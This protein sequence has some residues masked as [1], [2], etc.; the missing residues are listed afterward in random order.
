MVDAVQ[1]AVAVQKEFHAHNVELPE[2]RRMLFR[3]GVNL[4]D[5]IEE[6][7]RI[8]G[9]GV[10][11]AARIESI[12]DP[13]GICVSKTAFDHIESKLPLGY[14]FLGEQTVKNIAKPVG[15]YKVLMES[16]IT[17]KPAL[18][19]VPKSRPPKTLKIALVCLSALVV[20]VGA[21][22]VW[23][24][25]LHRAPAP[26]GKVDLRKVV[27]APAD[28]TSIEVLPFQN[29]TGDHEQEYF[30]DGMAEQLI[31]GL[32]QTPDIYVAARTSS[33]AFKGK[34]MTAQQISEQL[35]VRYLLEGSVQRDADRVRI[36]VQL[37]E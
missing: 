30:S 8:Y 15:A 21:A 17:T 25:A 16:R 10:N 22:A 34:P 5:V 9:D 32:S 12:A 4:G 31:T 35:G 26:P 27:F 14:E 29:M 7:D 36:N 23:Q 6:G 24:F 19:D 1:C 28:K 3:I 11:I 33:F 13:G 37:I 2:H 18:P 20:A